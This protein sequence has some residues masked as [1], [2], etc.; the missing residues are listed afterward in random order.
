MDTEILYSDAENFLKFI[1]LKICRGKFAEHHGSCHGMF[2]NRSKVVAH[3]RSET[4]LIPLK[5]IK[6][7]LELA[8][9]ASLVVT[10]AYLSQ[11]LGCVIFE[12]YSG[13]VRMKVFSSNFDR[14]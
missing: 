1:N 14:F 2:R 10:R 4:L 6:K 11:L 7:S 13:D 12:L 8:P 5:L 3:S 9:D